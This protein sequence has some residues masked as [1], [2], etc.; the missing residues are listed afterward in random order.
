MS[1][2]RRKWATRN[3]ERKASSWRDFLPIHPAAELLPRMLDDDLR[4][5]G[6]DIKK[7]NLRAAIAVWKEQKH[8]PVQ[9]LDGRS[10]LDAM[11]AV[12]IKIKIEFCG[13]RDA[14]P[15]ADGWRR[16]SARARSAKSPGC[17][18]ASK[19][20]KP[21]SISSSARTSICRARSRTS[22]GAATRRTIPPRCDG[23]R[24]H[25]DVEAYWRLVDE[26]VFGGHAGG[27]PSRGKHARKR[28][29]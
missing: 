10:R 27:R 7:N 1:I 23:G 9:L 17:A 12:G 25:Q 16:P 14:S 18:P 13:T 4:E 3:G 21:K 15:E 29:A 24:R 20:W 11:E 19:S 6:E 22:P 28:S 5:L 26:T 8:L 2:P